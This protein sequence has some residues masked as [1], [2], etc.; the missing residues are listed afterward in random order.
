M[1]YRFNRLAHDRWF[2]PTSKG[3]ALARSRRDLLA[4]FVAGGW[5]V[6]AACAADPASAELVAAE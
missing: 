3:F 1:F 6:V 4:R 5:R 2:E